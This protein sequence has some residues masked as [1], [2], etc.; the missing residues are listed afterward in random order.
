MQVTENDLRT[1]YELTDT[2]ELIE[3]RARNTLT[4]T[5]V[6]VLNQ[7]LIE[8]GVS[9]DLQKQVIEEHKDENSEQQSVL[10]MKWLNFWAYFRYPVGSLGTLYSILILPST[11]LPPPGYKIAISIGLFGAFAMLV[12][13][14]GLHRRRIWAWWGNWIFI[15]LDTLIILE[16]SSLN[17]ILFLIGL[18]AAGVWIWFNFVYWEK[19][20]AWFT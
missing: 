18:C 3:L 7:V 15:V 8:R 14:F 20:R 6:A 10:G 9:K 13:S 5:A 11:S 2:E 16:Q 12:M 1:H 4:D 19:R 17:I